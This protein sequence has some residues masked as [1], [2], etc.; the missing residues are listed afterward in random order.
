MGL[1][2]K[3]YAAGAEI[4]GRKAH[5]CPGL[6]VFRAITRKGGNLPLIELLQ[7]RG[8]ARIADVKAVERADK[9]GVHTFFVQ[10]IQSVAAFFGAFGRGE[11][12]VEHQLKTQL[13]S[14]GLSIA[15][16]GIHAAFLTI[17]KHDA[18]FVEAHHVVKNAEHGRPAVNLHAAG[19]VVYARV[20][21]AFNHTS[22]NG[23]SHAHTQNGRA[24][25][26]DC[27]QGLYGCRAH[28]HHKVKILALQKLFCQFRQAAHLLW[29]PTGAQAGICRVFAAQVVIL[30]HAVTKGVPGIVKKP[31]RPGLKIANALD[32]WAGKAGGAAGKAQNCCHKGNSHRHEYK[33][34]KAYKVLRAQC[35]HEDKSRTNVHA[36]APPEREFSL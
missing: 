28:A 33:A 30:A 4:P 36:I 23:V 26:V 15:Q 1:T 7:Q 3:G 12:V 21:C 29:L 34:C 25:I 31:E 11:P 19:K 9:K 22:G 8:H 10:C 24:A 14:N 16:C 13:R 6:D 17:L 20:F 27:K 2:G 32:W 18:H 5:E 35:G